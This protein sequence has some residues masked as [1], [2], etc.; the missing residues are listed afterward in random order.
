MKY[1]QMGVRAMNRIGIIKEAIKITEEGQ[2]IVNGKTVTLQHSLSELKHSIFL[3]EKEVL[4]II[5]EQCERNKNKEKSE[6]DLHIIVTNRD[7]LG[8]AMDMCRK[9]PAGGV[10]VLNFANPVNP[11]GGVRFGAVAQEED[12][13]VKSTLLFSFE[14]EEAAGYYRFHKD[15]SF[16]NCVT[17]S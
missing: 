2:Y 14:S 8:A 16:D 11:G 1:K 17:H 10:A 15:Q 9:T 12:L 6:N 3:S 4:N 5:E 7:T 13:C